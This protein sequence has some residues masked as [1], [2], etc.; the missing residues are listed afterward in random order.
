MV[1]FSSKFYFLKSIMIK[2]AHK[3]HLRNLGKLVSQLKRPNL[4]FKQEKSKKKT[5]TIKFLFKWNHLT[6]SLTILVVG[7]M[8]IDNFLYHLKIHGLKINK[9]NFQTKIKFFCECRI[10]HVFYNSV[11]CLLIW[12]FFTIISNVISSNS[13]GKRI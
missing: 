8:K 9:I 4:F 7:I 6:Q 10:S 5:I 12:Y 2:K 3:K 11:I 13:A 1:F